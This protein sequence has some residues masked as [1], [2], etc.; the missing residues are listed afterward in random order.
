[1]LRARWM[2]TCCQAGFTSG[3]ASTL[4]LA[5]PTRCLASV[6]MPGLAACHTWV[7]SIWQLLQPPLTTTACLLPCVAGGLK[8]RTGLRGGTGVSE[9]LPER[10]Q[11]AS[12][13]AASGQ[14]RAGEGPGSGQVGKAGQPA[15]S[16]AGQ[17][18]SPRS[19]CRQPSAAQR[20]PA[21][22][23]ARCSRTQGK[24]AAPP[25]TAGRLP[26]DAR[27][28]LPPQMQQPPPPQPQPQTQPPDAQA[29]AGAPL[30][31]P[32]PLVQA[33]AQLQAQQ[34]QFFAARH[35]GGLAPAAALPATFWPRPMQRML[36]F[37]VAGPRFPGHCLLVPNGA[38]IVGPGPFGMAAGWAQPVL[39][40]PLQPPPPPGAG[41]PL[42]H[43]SS[44]QSTHD[45]EHRLES[46]PSGLSGAAP[47]QQRRSSGSAGSGARSRGRNRSR[48]RSAGSTGGARRS[49]P[50]R[51][52]WSRSGGRGTRSGGGRSGGDGGRCRSRSCSGGRRAH[53]GRGRSP[54]R[55]SRDP[56]QRSGRR[57]G[58]QP[59]SRSHSRSRSRS[60]SPRRRRRLSLP[61][62]HGPLPQ[63][64]TTSLPLWL[65][66]MLRV[67]CQSCAFSRGLPFHA[68]MLL[69]ALDEMRGERHCLQGTGLSLHHLCDFLE[70]SGLAEVEV[71]R[72]GPWVHRVCID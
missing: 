57:P 37:P 7:R 13:G 35:F 25:A 18:G 24:A 12:T 52:S 29:A 1:M 27:D 71:E 68:G 14:L 45:I 65:P 51:H 41:Q 28:R 23:Q 47:A 67:A 17:I 69:P 5:C 6:Y 66:A 9:T 30:P 15:P 43:L 21:G 40:P 46:A 38:T 63:P 62:G 31:L 72:D 70:V 2:A 44:G 3:C 53:S 32:L 22:Q 50:G 8:I 33:Q 34:M 26:D 36:S 60:R 11:S 54:A 48:S 39:P 4:L 19:I 16:A 58:S 42:P 49:S 55:G 20:Q 64:G 10:Q 59:R 56:R 61:L